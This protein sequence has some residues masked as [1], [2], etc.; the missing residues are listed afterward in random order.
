MSG[1]HVVTVDVQQQRFDLVSPYARVN[2]AN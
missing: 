1:A 2:A